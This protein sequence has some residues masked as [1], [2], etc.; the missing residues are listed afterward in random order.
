MFKKE[1]YNFMCFILLVSSDKYLWSSNDEGLLDQISF[2][3]A[4]DGE[5][6]FILDIYRF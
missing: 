5:L 4:A 3:I 1:C 2:I 6:N